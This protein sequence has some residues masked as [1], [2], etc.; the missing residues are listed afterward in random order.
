M[1]TLA[2]HNGRVIDPALGRDGI[3]DVVIVDGR[4]ARVGPGEGAAVVEADRID[5]TGLVV[6]P[7]FVDLHVHLREPGFEYKETIATGTAAAARGGFTTVCAMPNTD[8]PLDRRSAVES[9]LREAEISG[10]IR[11]LPLGC[12]TS[13]RAGV[14][15]AS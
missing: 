4:I 6:A 8:P 14:E 1:S 12:I 9:V 13:G 10:L 11:V 7:G 5:A 15:L 2:I 3:A